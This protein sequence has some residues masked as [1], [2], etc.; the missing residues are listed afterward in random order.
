MF[1]PR[2]ISEACLEASKQ[3]AALLLT[4]PRQ[5]GKTTLLQRLAK[6]DRNYVTLDDPAARTLAQADPALFLERFEPPVLIDEIQYAPQL[7][8]LIKMAVDRGGRKRPSFW[9]TGSQ[10]FQLMRGISETL[11]GRVAILNLLGL[12]NRER[13]KHNLN[14]PPFLPTPTVLKARQADATVLT[15]KRAYA[16]IWLGSFPALVTK[17]V[18]DRDLFYSSYLQTYLQRDVRDL[19]QVGNEASFI[20]FLKACAARTAQMLNL[21]DLARDADIAV[22]TAKNWLSVLQASFQVALLQ[23]YHSNLTKRLV[24]APK[25]YFLDTGLCSYLAEWSS[26]QTLEAGA[27]SGPMLETHVFSEVLKSWWNRGKQPQLFYYRDKEGRE[28]DLLIMQDR[29]MHPIEV[30]K[31]GSPRPDSVAG[32]AALDRLGSSVGPGGVICLSREI[33]P[34][35]RG[36][37][38]VPLGLL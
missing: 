9:L 33:L 17:A 3:F 34:I 31:A 12:S 18:R 8:P 2:A 22:N 14:V 27:M 20:R 26:P 30:K 6:R 37:T 1:L 35:R 36:V 16:D 21:S 23:P 7:L 4:G 29:K 25:L 38:A 32:F 15:L 24:K 11:A 10:Q 28:I 5:V 19:T 13:R